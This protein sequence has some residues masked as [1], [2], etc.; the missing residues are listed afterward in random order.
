MQSGNRFAVR[1]LAFAIF[2]V[3]C[4]SSAWA[5]QEDEA[6]KTLSPVV[7][8]GTR[9]ENRT[10]AESLQPIQVVSAQALEGSGSS[11]LGEALSRV[12]PSLNFPRPASSGFTGIIRPAQMRGLGPDQVLVLVNGKRRHNSALV[13]TGSKIGKGTTPVDFNAIPVSAIKRI[14]VLRDGAGALYGSDAV[15]G[16]I[17]VILDDAPE[18][19]AIEASFGAHHTDLAPIGRTLTDGQTSYFS[20]KVG[21]ALTEEGGFLRVGLEYKNREA[22]NRAGFDQ[23]PPWEAQTA[24]NLALAG[25]RNYALGDGASKDINAWFNTEIPF[26]ATSKAYAFGTYNQRDTEGANYFRYPDGKANWKQLYPHGYRPVSEGENL[27]VQLVGGARG[28]WGEW[29][30]DASVDHGRNEFT[31]RLRNS[32]NASLGPASPTRFKTGDFSF[33]QTVA[34]LDLGR[35][36]VRGNDSHSLGFG[37]EGRHERYETGAGDPASYA[38]GPYTD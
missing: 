33:E 10:A 32:L 29:N 23:I 25:K 4:A 1:Q 37:I 20:A 35:V 38:A 2:N 19:G 21:T 28:Q 18:G 26:G 31:Y 34:N 16:V 5:A 27:D 17:N 6:A 24:D 7:V 36:F 13:N 14:E 12:V 9:A 30:Y 22:T 11:E 3:I 8:T 15:A